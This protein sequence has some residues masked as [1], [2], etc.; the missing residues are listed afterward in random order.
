MRLYLIS[1]FCLTTLFL[2][3]QNVFVTKEKVLQELEARN[4]DEEEVKEALKEQ[5]IELDY[6][7][8]GTLSQALKAR[9][10]L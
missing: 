10:L 2:S 7:D 1:I 9:T 4:L 3:G 6:L 8:E 5:G